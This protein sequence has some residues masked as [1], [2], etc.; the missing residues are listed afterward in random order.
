MFKS[1]TLKSCWKHFKIKKNNN[2]SEGSNPHLSFKHS[3][4]RHSVLRGSFNQFIAT[5]TDYLLKVFD[6]FWITRKHQICIATT[7]RW[8]VLNNKTLIH[9]CVLLPSGVHMTQSS[10]ILNFVVLP[11]NCFYFRESDRLRW[12]CVLYIDTLVT[13]F[14]WKNK[15]LL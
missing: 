6:T 1:Q 4:T 12:N 3:D 2:H 9:N 15:I 14:F 11:K 8:T 7:D 13:V 5:R 10:A